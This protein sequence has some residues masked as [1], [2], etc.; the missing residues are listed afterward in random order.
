MAN[1]TLP[2]VR[3]FGHFGVLCTFSN[4]PTAGIARPPITVQIIVRPSRIPK[5]SWSGRRVGSFLYGLTA[6]VVLTWGEGR[7]EAS[8]ARSRQVG[9][10]RRL[11][12]PIF[13]LC[14]GMARSIPLFCRSQIF[15]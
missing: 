8:V 9:R 6:S 5:P 13:L 1:W 4:T 3:D 11:T 2:T 15:L 7:P 12:A 10:Y 14:V